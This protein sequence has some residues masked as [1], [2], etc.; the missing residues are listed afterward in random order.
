MKVSVVLPTYNE[1][2]NICLL[3][4]SIQTQLARDHELEI[5][6]VDDNSPDGTLELVKAEFAGDSTVVPVLR[7]TDRGLPRSIR[8]GI[9]RSTG[10]AIVI[11]DT[12]FTH[13][14]IYLATIVHLVQA[15][16]VV[17]GSRFSAG[18]GMQDVAHYLLSMAF[19]W[20]IRITLRTQIQDNL[21]GY[22]A[23]D[24]AV[25]ASLPMD[26]IFFGYGDYCFRLLH[27]AQ[28]AGH[29]VI[30]MPVQ[31]RDRHTG[32][33]KSNFFKMLFDYSA[34]V[35]RLRWVLFGEQRTRV[36]PRGPKLCAELCP[37]DEVDKVTRSASE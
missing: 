1:A 19:N 3:V 18:G 11:L 30:E 31:Y 22:L 17:V 33:S 16:D 5:L 25:L 21:S 36:A 12:D 10:D 32:R 34:A 28:R 35:L 2:G 8:E 29:R 6:V 7:V 9:E 13:D 20:F 4:R 37:R 23:L 15:Y 26:Q 14:P 27:Y 24:R